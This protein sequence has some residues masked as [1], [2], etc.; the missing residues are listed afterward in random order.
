MMMM[1][2]NCCSYV[3]GFSNVLLNDSNRE[4]YR[5]TVTLGHLFDVMN[6]CRTVR[7][8]S[9][10]ESDCEHEKRTHKRITFGVLGF[11]FLSQ[12]GGGGLNSKWNDDVDICFDDWIISGWS[13]MPA[14]LLSIVFGFNPLFTTGAFSYNEI[15]G[16]QMKVKVL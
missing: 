12:G 1:L 8:F 5:S 11:N 14:N 4:Q 2:K 13:L 15:F 10:F 3:E 6:V 7:K 9:N 16:Q